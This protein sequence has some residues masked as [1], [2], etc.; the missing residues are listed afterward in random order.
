MFSLSP[1][2]VK[3]KAG[4]TAV[5]CVKIIPA[6]ST[7]HCKHSIYIYWKNE[8]TYVKHLL[9]KKYSINGYYYLVI[10]IWNPRVQYSGWHIV[11]DHLSK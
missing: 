6:S 11:R 8:V 2:L 10:I 7:V 5:L 4:T 9:V 1:R 3:I